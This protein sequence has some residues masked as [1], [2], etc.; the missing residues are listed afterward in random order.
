M[1]DDHGNRLGPN[2]EGELHVRRY[3]G[4]FDGYYGDQEKTK[5]ST[6]RPQALL[7]AALWF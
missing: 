4:M 6:W 3:D 7:D 5:K 2:Q 1:F